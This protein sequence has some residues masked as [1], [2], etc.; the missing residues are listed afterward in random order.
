MT[1]K[2]DDTFRDAILQASS[3]YAVYGVQIDKMAKALKEGTA[4]FL[5]EENPEH[6]KAKYEG[7]A[8]A[9]AEIYPQLSEWKSRE[10]NELS[11]MG[12]KE[13][14]ATVTITRTNPC[15][16]VPKSIETGRWSSSEGF[17]QQIPRENQDR[18]D[19]INDYMYKLTNPKCLCG[20]DSVHA[21][22]SARMHSH[23]CPKHLKTPITE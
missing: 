9:Y 14:W 7:K 8:K 1:K 12:V 4:I 17:S 16:E 5:S 19:R 11:P 3:I 13:E 2:K 20:I 6:I 23:Y 22:A 10:L 18:I 21:N 15:S